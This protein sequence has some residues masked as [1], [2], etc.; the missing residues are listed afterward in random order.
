MVRRVSLVA[1]VAL[2][3]SSLAQDGAVP[4]SEY[5]ARRARVANPIG[6]DGVVVAFWSEPARRT[7]DVDWPFRQEDSL[8]YLTGM[9]VP[10]TTLVLLPGE[11]D[12]QELI[13]ATDRDPSTERWTGRIRSPQ[14]VTAVTGVREVRSARQVDAFVDALFR[15]TPFGDRSPGRYYTPPVAPS[16]LSAFR[17]G[18]AEVWLLLQDRGSRRTL[19]R[20]QQFAEELRR[21]YPE[22]KIRDASPAL[23]AMREIK[24]PSE[25]ALIQRAVDI[26]VA[27]QKAAMARVLTAT[28]ESEVQATVEFTFRNLGACCW[29]FPSLVAAGRNATTLHYETNND[30]IVRNRLL[31]TDIGAEERGSS[32]DVTRT[33]PAGG[34]F[35]TEQRA[36]YDVVLAAQTGTLPLM[37]PGHRFIEIH[38]RAQQVVGRELLKLGLVTKNTPE[39]SELYLFHGPGHPLCL[40]THDVYDRLRTFE[41]NMVFTNEP[42]VSVRRNDVIESDVF[43]KLTAAEQ[44][45]VRAALDRYDGI[46]VRI[47]DDV[48]ITAGEPRIMSAGAPRAARDIEALMAKSK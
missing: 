43:K 31:L 11:P 39:Q 7:G 13:F 2:P 8:L 40:Q 34:T 46:G 35:S 48:R 25:L 37:R 44:Q 36:V 17:A 41:P 38:D 47:E 24:S 9:N 6:A 20:E 15:G 19:T 22:V 14:E 26:T 33:Y 4:P 27:A 18:R 32:A 21:R 42:G 1:A 28:R 16:V 30:P 23:A 12:H 3:V 5:Q 45:S 10:D 29:A